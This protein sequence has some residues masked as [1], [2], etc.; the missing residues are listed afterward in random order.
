[1]ATISKIKSGQTLYDKHRYKMGNTTM[2]A[3]GVWEVNV[4]SVDPN[5]QFIFASW[6]G[7]PPRKMY[8]TEVYKL[9]V[10]EPKKE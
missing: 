9:R 7:N 2:Y 5:G 1:M 10:R 4:I 6:N 8:E 3:W